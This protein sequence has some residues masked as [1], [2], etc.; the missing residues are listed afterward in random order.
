MVYSYSHP[1]TYILRNIIRNLFYCVGY[2]I[3][4][5]ERNLF[6]GQVQ[7]KIGQMD[8]RWGA[9]SQRGRFFGKLF[10]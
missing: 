3:A 10:L 1:H 4:K 7:W 5:G 6:C 8:W 9:R 2:I